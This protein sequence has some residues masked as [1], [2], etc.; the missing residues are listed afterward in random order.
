M[1]LI[2]ITTNHNPNGNKARKQSE[3]PTRFYDFPLLFALKTEICTWRRTTSSYVL[4]KRLHVHSTDVVTPSLVPEIIAKGY[5]I[6][7]SRDERLATRQQPRT[8][9]W[10]IILS[11]SVKY[12]SVIHITQRLK[13][14]CW[15]MCS[16]HGGPVMCWNRTGKF[17]CTANS[18][19]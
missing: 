11:I 10:I 16:V 5:G 3:L 13:S 1:S 6:G 9:R 12:I 19:R 14:L 7:H 18:G 4:G 8:Q 15:S 17:L 2:K